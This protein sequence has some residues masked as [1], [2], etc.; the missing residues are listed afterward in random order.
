[1]YTISEFS[2]M[3]GV[4]VATVRF[5]EKKGVCSPK[6]LDNG[7]RVFSHQDAFKINAFKMLL[8]YGFSIEEALSLSK[9]HSKDEYSSILT[10][11]KE[12]LLEEIEVLKNKLSRIQYTLDVIH[13][14]PSDNFQVRKVEDY[15]YIPFS[16][17][18]DFSPSLENYEELSKLV[19][20]LDVTYYARK[21]PKED[22]ILSKPVVNPSYI[23]V[24][25]VNDKDHL[26]KNVL[27]R[28]RTFHMGKCIVYYREKT[29]KESLS[30]DSYSE[31]IDF[32]ERKNLQ[33]RSDILLL[34]SFL[35]LDDG[36]RDIEKLLVP[37]Y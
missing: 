20:K 3:V 37:I 32:M 33:I 24:V 19:S 23:Q 18:L 34:P 26:D 30:G 16:S 22:V 2:K 11:Q 9:S 28:A 17:G 5:Y 1:M 10:G 14:F 27:K 35:Q 31:L 25:S 4:S 13:R 8:Q 12:T 7:Y 36:G 6:R 15:L 29:R 21:I